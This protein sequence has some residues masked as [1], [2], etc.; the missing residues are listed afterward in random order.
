MNV[1]ASSLCKYGTT[2]N[3]ATISGITVGG[4]PG[5]PNFMCTTSAIL[6]L[7]ATQAT[8]TTKINGLNVQGATSIM[9]GA[10][11]G[12]RVLSPTEP[13]TQAE[14]Y[15]EAETKKVLVLMSDGRNTYYPNNKFVKSWYEQYGYVTM[16]HLG[17]TST[18]SGTLSTAMDGRTTAACTNIKAAGII[19][20]TV[21]FDISGN[22]ADD[23]AARNVLEGCATEPEFFHEAEDNEDL[24]AAFE[25]IGDSIRN[26]H[27]AR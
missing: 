9:E 5:G 7:T 22:D 12:W 1:S 2:T 27:I 4:I 14:P 15:D 11:W 20:Y 6:P 17:T 8:V 26:L 10:M 23:V 21:G 24:V 25:A 13:F 18:D 3:K 16:N 19:V